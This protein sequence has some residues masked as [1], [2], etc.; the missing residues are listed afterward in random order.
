MRFEYVCIYLYI[1]GRKDRSNGERRGGGGGRSRLINDS[2][3]WAQRTRALP[4]ELP[5]ELKNTN[6]SNTQKYMHT[7]FPCYFYLYITYIYKY[8]WKIYINIFK[9]MEDSYASYILRFTFISIKIFHTSSL[10]TSRDFFSFSKAARIDLSVAKRFLICFH[11]N[12]KWRNLN[13]M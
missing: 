2:Y 12:K 10:K 13:K 7:R 1:Y 8:I 6:I 4:R 11:N 3:S 5:K 9:F